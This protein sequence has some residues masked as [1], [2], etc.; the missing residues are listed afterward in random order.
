[1]RAQ[2]N[3]FFQMGDKENPRPGL[4]QHGGNPVSAQAIGIGLDHGRTGGSARAGIEQAVIGGYGI[5]I[6]FQRGARTGKRPA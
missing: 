5:Q 1:M 2:A 3:A 4:F 6:D